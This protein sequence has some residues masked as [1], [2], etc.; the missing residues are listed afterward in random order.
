MGRNTLA[1]AALIQAVWLSSCHTT[2]R[3]QGAI[4]EYFLIMGL[5]FIRPPSLNLMTQVPADFVSRSVQD[6]HECP[7]HIYQVV[8]HLL[9]VM[10]TDSTSVHWR[11][12]LFANAFLLFLLPE[13]SPKTAARLARHFLRTAASD[14]L[15]LRQLAL[16]ALSFQ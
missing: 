4:N 11:Y 14:I 6:L 5:R 3:A 15:P 10:E 13:Y 9:S 2:V 8:E 12:L 1:M 16:A 7:E